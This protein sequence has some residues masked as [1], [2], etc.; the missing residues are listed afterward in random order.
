MKIKTSEKLNAIADTVDILDVME[1]SDAA[2]EAD[3]DEVDDVT[4]GIH[5]GLDLRKKIEKRF[6]TNKGDIT[7][8][9]VCP[10]GWDSDSTAYFIGSE[11]EV[12]ERLDELT[13]G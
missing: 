6:R 4:Q 5:I 11:D 3:A 13:K 8:W 7:I 12:M 1:A 9:A 10:E 2:Y